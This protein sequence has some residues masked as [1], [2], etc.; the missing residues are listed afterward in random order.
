MDRREIV[1]WLVLNHI[2]DGYESVVPYILPGVVK[3]GA[4]F[5][6][7]IDYSEVVESLA[8]LIADGLAKA[9]A[10]SSE[11]PHYVP[12]EG[13]PPDDVMAEESFEAS[14]LATEVGVSEMKRLSEKHMSKDSW[15]PFDDD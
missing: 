7:I 14:F 4:K 5:G 12:L 10:L 11:E 6:W 13:M 1:R 2:C 8:G 3:I 15:W 9:Y